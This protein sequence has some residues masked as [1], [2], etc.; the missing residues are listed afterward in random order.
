MLYF[1]QADRPDSECLRD[2]LPTVCATSDGVHGSPS[3]STLI[4]HTTS[5]TLRSIVSP[6]L[7]AV[8]IGKGLSRPDPTQ[9][10]QMVTIGNQ[11]QTNQIGALVTCTKSVS[12]GKLRLG[13][14]AAAG[15]TLYHVLPPHRIN[16]LYAHLLC[17]HPCHA[18]PP[19]LRPGDPKQAPH[20]QQMKTA[21][22]T[23]AIAT[24]MVLVLLQVHY[25]IGTFSY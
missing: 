7:A 11:I 2:T 8:M 21:I 15:H 16:R 17:I 9:I 25:C 23:L 24:V 14:N 10:D 3:L 20:S 6:L 4:T 1:L 5:P 22:K 18:G 12:N 19:D 13:S